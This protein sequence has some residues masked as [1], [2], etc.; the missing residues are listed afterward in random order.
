M[1][2]THT[3]THRNNVRCWLFHGTTMRPWCGATR[4]FGVVTILS[5]VAMVGILADEV[6]VPKKAC[7][8]TTCYSLEPRIDLDN[9]SWGSG[10]CQAYSDNVI[11]LCEPDLPNR[12]CWS[13]M[14]PPRALCEGL[15]TWDNQTFCDFTI[16]LCNRTSSP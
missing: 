14:E 4:F 10:W 13:N 8:H 7:I 16:P 2:H 1:T 11:D 15:C 5:F 6:G 9:C 3:H 12:T